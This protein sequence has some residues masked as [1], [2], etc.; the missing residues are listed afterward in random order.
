V[1]GHNA[2]PIHIRTASLTASLTVNSDEPSVQ[3][4]Q[5]LAPVAIPTQA[6][7]NQAEAQ[8]KTNVDTKVDEKKQEPALSS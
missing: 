7:H 3:E 6:T 2:N 5:V 4:Q 1:V 8:M